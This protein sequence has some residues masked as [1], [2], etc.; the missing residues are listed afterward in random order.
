MLD[1]S[2]DN[3][4]HLY[5]S[6]CQHYASFMYYNFIYLTQGLYIYEY[7]GGR[8]G[9]MILGFGNNPKIIQI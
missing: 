1:M 9:G 8:G 7:N 2:Y 4:Q 5:T 3:I 6:V